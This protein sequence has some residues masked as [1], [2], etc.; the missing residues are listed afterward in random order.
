MIRVMEDGV[1]VSPLCATTIGAM[2]KRRSTPIE[3]TTSVGLV[4]MMG[5]GKGLTKTFLNHQKGLQRM[6]LFKPS[7][8]FV[9]EEKEK[10]RRG[11][12]APLPALYTSER[13]MCF[14]VGDQ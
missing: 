2:L 13:W 7:L 4:P 12:V 5:S 1:P 9:V 14:S 11:A 8:Q 10:A 6:N 3:Q